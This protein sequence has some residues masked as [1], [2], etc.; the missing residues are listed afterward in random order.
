MVFLEKGLKANINIRTRILNLANYTF[1]KLVVV[2]KHEV[3]LRDLLEI[4]NF[5][6]KYWFTA[7]TVVGDDFNIQMSVHFLE[8][9]NFILCC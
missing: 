9:V 4:R 7:D 6:C 2:L 3:D 5:I 1:L 8:T